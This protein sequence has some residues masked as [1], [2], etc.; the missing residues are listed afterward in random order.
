MKHMTHADHC[1]IDA[2]AHRASTIVVSRHGN[3]TDSQL[4]AEAKAGDQHAFTELC[5]RYAPVTKRKIFSIVKNAQDAEDVLQE[6]LLRAYTHL[7]GFRGACRF[8]TW[9]TRIGINQALMLRRKRKHQPIRMAEMHGSDMEAT[10]LSD[11]PDLSPDPEQLCAKREKALLLRRA[12]QRQRPEFRVI[13]D[14]YYQRELSLQETA[15][16]LGISVPAAKSRLSRGRQKVRRAI[17]HYG[18]GRA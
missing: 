2:S 15:D 10:E 12:V 4:L 8:S 18:I 3:V 5:D 13:I 17:E 1:S 7:E 6:T 9:I 14:T 16:A 11:P